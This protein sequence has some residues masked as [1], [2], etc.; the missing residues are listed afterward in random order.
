MQASQRLDRFG[1]EVFASLNNKLLALKAQGKTIYNMSVGT[2][3]FK[4]YDHVV[5]AL[6]HAAQDPEM[7]KYALR[8]LPELK[9]AVCDYYERRF[10]VS[11]ITPSMVQS[12]NGTQEGVGHLGLA[13]LDPGDS[14]LVPDPCYPVFEAGA[15]IADAKLEYYPLVAE[16]N[17]LPYVAG[18][19]P[20]V[21]DRAKYM[22][23]S[24]PA[25]P[26]G[27]VGTPEVYEEIIAF[28]REHDLLIVHDNAYSDIV[29]DGEPGGSFLQYPGALEV[30]VEFFSLSKSFNVTGARIG[31][32]VGREDVV[33]AF[34]KLRGQIDFGMFFP[35]QKA[36]IA[37]LNGPRDEVEAQRL[38]Y[39]ERRDALCD[40]LEGLGWE[41]PNAHGSMFVWAKLP[42]G[43][44]DSMAFCEELME[45]A[46]VVVTP[47]ASFGPSGE[48]HVRM[49]LVLPPDQIALAVEAI[50]EAGLY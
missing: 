48:G 9:Q 4:P 46:G 27:S 43:R 39:Q 33:S 12:C 13:L 18:I 21:A 24:L 35:I 38:K 11:G 7:W 29:F 45:K 49:A 25:N 31:F 16:H 34:A 15:K 44:T 50:R 6:T 23:V 42:G 1:A 32:L 41:R 8:D 3:D 28:A 20:E 30:G 19:D 22:I 40:G 14:I 5:E 2:P 37:C 17:Y 26:V 10:G 47:G 36:A